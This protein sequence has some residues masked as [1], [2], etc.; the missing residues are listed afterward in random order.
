MLHFR[1]YF[2]VD[3]IFLSDST[4]TCLVLDIIACISFMYFHFLE[5]NS[6]I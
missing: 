5:V 6:S 2:I 3:V 4:G 1:V